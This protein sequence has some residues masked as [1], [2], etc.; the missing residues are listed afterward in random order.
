MVQGTQ[1]PVSLME[2]GVLL[3]LAPREIR[4]TKDMAFKA[5]ISQRSQQRPG[6]H[7][8]HGNKG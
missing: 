5:V 8:D 3:F 6:D 1:N 7:G 2:T 4:I